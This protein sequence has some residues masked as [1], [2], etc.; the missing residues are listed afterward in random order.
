MAST[1]TTPSPGAAEA[2]TDTPGSTAR[3]QTRPC[4][5]N[6]VSVQPPTS[7]TRTG[8]CTSTLV[9]AVTRSSC[10][11][12]RWRGG[13]RI[14]GPV[15]L[16][17]APGHVLAD[18]APR[19]GPEAREVRRS[20]GPAGRR[21]T[22][23]ARPAAPAPAPPPGGRWCRTGP[24]P[25]PR[26]R[27]A[28]PCSRPERRARSPR[29]PGWARGG[30]AR[31]PGGG[32]RGPAGCAR[33]RSARG[34]LGRSR[35]PAGAPASRRATSS[36]ASSV[37][38]GQ[39]PPSARRAKPM[40]ACSAR[41]TSR[42][43]STVEP[44]RRGPGRRGRRSS[45]R[46]ALGPSVAGRED[47]ARRGGARMR[48]RR[49]SRAASHPSVTTSSM[50]LP[51]AAVDVGLVEPGRHADAEVVVAGAGRPAGRGASRSATTRN[52]SPVERVARREAPPPRRC[53]A[54]SGRRHGPGPG[55]RGRRG[56]APARTRR[57]RRRTGAGPSALS[58]RRS[59]PARRRTSCTVLRSAAGWLDR[60]STIS[61]TR[62]AT[63]AGSSSGRPRRTSRSSSSAASA[64]A[65]PPRPR[66]VA[67]RTMCARRGW[68][69]S[70]AIARPVVVTRWSASRA[71]S[72]TSRSRASASARAGGGSRN[73][74]SLG[75]RA[76]HRQLERQPGQVD[77]LDL[78][79]R[80]RPPVGVL[81]RRTTG[82]RR[83]PARCARPA[84]LAG[85]PTLASSARCASRVSPLRG[86]VA[87]AAHLSAVDHDRHAVHG[88]AGLGDV[89]GEHDPS[90]SGRRRGQRQVL[91][92]ERERTEERAH[93][94][95]GGH[96]PFQRRR[97][98]G[99]CRRRRRGTRA[100]RRRRSAAPASTAADTAS[101]GRSRGSGGRHRMSTGCDRPSLA[102]TG[103]GDLG[104]TE[105]R[106]D[107]V[108]V[109][110]GRHGQHAELGP[111][112]RPGV[113][114]QRQREVG[115]EVPLVDL[116]EDHEPDAGE[117]RVV[118]EAAGEDPLGH[119]LDPAVPADLRARRGCGSRRFRR[120]PRRAA[121]PCGGRRP[122]PRAAAV[123]A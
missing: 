98:P 83:R 20:P 29:P 39:S 72:S 118:L 15:V 112:H 11:R 17:V 14:E 35:R 95:V 96:R 93:V 37:T 54:G 81:A 67:A 106:R 79:R 99:G 94:D 121:R 119:H 89:G 113:E 16:G 120:P 49:S 74:R 71:P 43:R 107:P 55:G 57:G 46:P 78:G 65:T 23:G 31:P 86:V 111:Q 115:L 4:P 84:R 40:R 9:T 117:G 108:G 8:T 33:G 24:G 10:P 110:R 12:A 123:R 103:A 114:R 92:G 122:G 32:R 44:G 50:A 59:S 28:R 18:L 77:R 30:R 36:R 41:S 82:G 88:E 26:S 66:S 100:R 116:V 19:P 101:A 48:C 5:A 64:Q 21:G 47:D 104:A 34:R 62:S 90:T 73:A 70:S 102:T 27:A 6:Q 3:L 60:G 51:A 87:G 22:G 13:R 85:R 109:E 38:S 105:Q 76:P 68:T 58:R 56:R 53:A 91:L 2:D 75:R 7:Q 25:A 45:P 80:E 63:L 61:R 1:V 69:G 42:H 52:A 97:P